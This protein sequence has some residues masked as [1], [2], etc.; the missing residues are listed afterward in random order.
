M[1]TQDGA[2]CCNQK[3]LAP[4]REGNWKECPK[5]QEKTKRDGTKWKS[6]TVLGKKAQSEDDFGR[7]LIRTS[8][9]LEFREEGPAIIFAQPKKGENVYTLQSKTRS[10]DSGSLLPL[11]G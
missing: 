4:L 10:G 1:R 11:T 5:N 2:G 9:D 3:I 7:D 8:E 6:K